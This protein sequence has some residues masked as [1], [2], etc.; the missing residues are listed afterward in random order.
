MGPGR[1]RQIRLSVNALPVAVL[2]FGLPGYDHA[3]VRQHGDRGFCLVARREI[4]DLE[5]TVDAV[6]IRIETLT[7][8]AFLVAVLI[9]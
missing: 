4:I 7:E 6:A 9:L 1:S 8:Y 3:S 2:V 5:F